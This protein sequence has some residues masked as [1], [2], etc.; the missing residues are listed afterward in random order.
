MS[1]RSCERDSS[2]ICCKHIVQSV[3]K[4]AS[5]KSSIIERRSNTSYNLE[6][7]YC[8]LNDPRSRLLSRSQTEKYLKVK[9]RG[10]AREEYESIKQK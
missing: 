6:C 8:G 1:T 10:M 4:R 5:W 2:T 7:D 3:V 9:E